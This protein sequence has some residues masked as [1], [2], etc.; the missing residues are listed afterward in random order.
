VLTVNQIVE[1]LLHF[2]SKNDWQQA[3][4]AVVPVRKT[5]ASHDSTRACDD[6]KR[7]SSEKSAN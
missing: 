4:E 6:G 7:V 3:C 1:L 2:Y 5:L